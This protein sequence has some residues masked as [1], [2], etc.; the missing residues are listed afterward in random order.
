VGCIGWVFS[1]VLFRL[2][3]RLTLNCHPMGNVQNGS[4]I[5]KDEICE[6]GEILFPKA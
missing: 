3:C 2:V 4:G 6:R 5:F 1:G